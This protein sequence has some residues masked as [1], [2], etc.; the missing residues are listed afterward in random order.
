MQSEIVCNSTPIISLLKISSLEIMEQVFPNVIIP[1][2]VFQE[3]EIGKNTKHYKDLSKL[4]WVHI[5][6]LKDES[7]LSFLIDLD[8]GEAETIALA[9]ELSIQKV[10]I[11]ERLGR[12]YAKEF[13][14]TVI[15][16]LG[17][18]LKAKQ[19]GIINSMK[20]LIEKLLEENIWFHE[21]LVHNVLD[22]ANE[23]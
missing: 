6:K 9:K 20:P 14:L 19:L 21:Q 10:I 11:D 3:I 8:K 13:G 18:L 16:T 2:Q 4:P 22:I 7:K 1:Y 12:K 15:G 5:V 23:I 17:I